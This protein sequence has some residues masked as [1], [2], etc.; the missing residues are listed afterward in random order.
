ML[1]TDDVGLGSMTDSNTNSNGDHPKK[2]ASYFVTLM[3]ILNTLIGA[4][5][6]GIPNSM[7][8]C[9][10]VPLLILLT[11]TAILSYIATILITRLQNRFAATSI[12]D[13]TDKLLGRW[14]GIILSILTLAFAYSCL[15][16]YIVTASDTIESWMKLAK[17]PEWTKGWKRAIVVCIY[18]LLIPVLLTT[19]RDLSYLNAASTF[20]IFSVVVYMVVMIVKAIQFFPHHPIDASVE[21]SDMNIHFFHA[22][23]LHSLMFALPGIVLPILIPY[24]PSLN[25]RYHVIGSAFVV[26]YILTIIPGV[27]GY[28]MFGATT[29]QI[30]FSSFPDNDW[31]IQVARVGFFVVLNA[32]YPVISMTV[33]T[34]LSNLLYKVGDPADATLKQRIVILTI[35]NIPPVLIGMVLPK[36]RP[37]LAIGGA[38]GGCLTNFTIPPLLWVKQSN[39]GWFH[40]TNILCYLFITFGV[41]SAG[42]ATY[43]AVEDAINTFKNN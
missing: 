39:C 29:N 9:G 40:W 20:A 14:G 19:P 43:E 22:F 33:L 18:S 30:I 12:N 3:N 10:L 26:C 16:A 37:A 6:L 25:K 31:M 15:I 23:A 28:L 1:P 42:I 7:T 17:I 35:N 34:E 27:I 4:E 38:F 2:Q 24:H 32:S 36:V 5:I 13:L 11:M 21:T 41:I 8:F